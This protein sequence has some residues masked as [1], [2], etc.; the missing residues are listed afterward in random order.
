MRWLILCLC[1][2]PALAEAVIA[3]RSLPARET[4]AASDIAVVKA[5][6]PG[7]ARSMDEVVGRELRVAVPA[8]RPLRPEDL[9][10]PAAVDRNQIVPLVYGTGAMLIRLEGRSLARAAQGE[11]VRVMNL[12]SRSIVLGIVMADGSVHVGPALTE[13]Q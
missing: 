8:G 11:V 2:V 6:I 13:T 7:A 4:V 9:I 12:Q 3:T 10:L 5:D 1:P